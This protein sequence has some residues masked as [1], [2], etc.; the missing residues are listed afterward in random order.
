M[1]RQSYQWV[2][3]RQPARIRDGHGARIGVVT[4]APA[5]FAVASSPRAVAGITRR[6]HGTYRALGPE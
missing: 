5:T 3:D 2:N 1:V 4:V 6:P